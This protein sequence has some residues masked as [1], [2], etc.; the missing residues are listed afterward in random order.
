MIDLSRNQQV[1]SLSIIRLVGYGLLLMAFVD[2]LSLII[3][4]QLMNPAW[5]FQTM[6][7]LVERIPVT[8]LGM[9][10]VFFGERSD[11]TPIETFLLRWLSR[12]S[13][14][15]AILFFLSIPLSI[16][17][18]FRIYYQHNAQVNLRIV[19]QIDSIKQ[20]KDKLAAANSLDQI[21]AIL[22]EQ[23]TQKITIPDSADTQK[24]KKSILQ[25]LKNTEDN[26][27]SQV[28]TLRSAK[29]SEL[30]K[31]SLKWN[32]GALIAAFLFLFI[33]KST[34]WARLEQNVD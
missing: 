2:F 17:G 15:V 29:R 24:L 13:L 22:A 31:N 1:F 20:F 16:S 26:L 27:N 19:P 33:W 3:P 7:A 28:E 14:I 32:L 21:R 34:L 4:P 10:L 30:L 23:A 6:G 25:N 18:S 5:E 11:R 9:V 8:L 12:L